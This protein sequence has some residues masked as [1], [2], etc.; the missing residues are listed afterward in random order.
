M[1]V[2]N[3]REFVVL[4]EERNYLVAADVLYSTQ[5]TLSRHIMA[6]E[7]EL[8]FTL[9]NRSTK[10]I[11]LT[12]EGNRFLLY[13]R[14]AIRIQ[15]AYKNA[16]ESAKQEKS[17]ILKVGYNPLVT[18]YHFSDLLTQ[19]MAEEPDSEI[20]IAQGESEELI[21]AVRDG[22]LEVAFI[23]EN[24]FEK[25]KNVDYTRFA[26]DIMVA[27]LPKNHRL[28]DAKKLEARQLKNDRFVMPDDKSNPAIIA[29]EACHR[30][31]FNPIVESSG[32]VGHA[33]YRMIA[34]S[35]C[36]ALD[37]K[38]PA[39]T[40]SDDSVALVDLEPPLYSNS[41]IIY[42]RENLSF[43]GKQLIRFFG[44]HSTAKEMVDL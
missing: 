21:N 7:E 3:M 18:F 43:A 37:W 33:M 44:A 26:T 38:V 39:Q 13:A 35:G 30:S 10:R 34:S 40:H 15:E 32:L 22:A 8:G 27:V 36:V 17:G 5:A 28:A 6:M 29:M 12:K 1:T 31:G 2:E 23:Q 19:F 11:E 24:P 16:I 41:L 25:P 20:K 42:N 14:N 4:S 9:F